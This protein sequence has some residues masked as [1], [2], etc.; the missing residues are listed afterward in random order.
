MERG[1][2]VVTVEKRLG[3]GGEGVVHAARL[4][5]APFAVKWFRPGPGNEEKRES[6]T[7]LIRRGR[8]PHPAFIWPID[9]VSSDRLPGFG[10]VMPLLEPRFISLARLLNEQ[11]PSLRATT[12]IGRELVD[13][14]A[15]LHS[16]GLCYRDISFGNLRADSD[17]GEVG[18]LDVDN[19]G[20]DGSGAQVKGTGP[21]MAPEILRDEAFPS[22]VTDLHS[23]AVMLFYMLMHGHPLLGVRT[24]AAYSWDQDNHLSETEVL[25]QHFGVHPL[26]IFDPDDSSNRPVP[27]HKVAD[28]WAIYPWQCRRVFTQA[29]TEGLRDASLNGRV[30]E[31]TWR[32]TLLS[33]HDSVASCAACGASLFHDPQQSRQ[34]CWRCAEL[35]PAPPRLTTPGGALVLSEGATVTS[36]HLN[37]DRDHRTA[38]AVVEP[39]PGRPGRVLMRNL[40]GKT[41]TVVAD[42]EERKSVA[43]SQRLGV[44]PMIID[45]GG[46]RGQIR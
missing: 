10:Y 11:D 32:R 6:I 31:G 42:G 9:L 40:T 25:T 5:G 3:E 41:W 46:A 18:I 2:T 33:L 28:W 7:A 39:H 17:A 19:I 20:I 27:G 16:A 14:F 29:F 26:F 35:L 44:R 34:G 1:S 38:C 12:T 13:A 8:P 30:I 36:H 43:P 15:A 22:T 23:L 4:N 21:F 24:D 37:R 45:F